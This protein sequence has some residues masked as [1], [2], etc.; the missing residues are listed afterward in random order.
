MDRLSIGPQLLPWLTKGGHS[1]IA[2]YQ[3]AAGLGV[4]GRQKALARELLREW[5]R[6]KALQDS[7][8]KDIDFTF[9]LTHS[10]PQAH[11]VSQSRPSDILDPHHH[12]G[13]TRFGKPGNADFHCT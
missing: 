7:S 4:S 10:I 8:V 5:T 9:R 11:I 3:A 13:W 1:D 2:P 12:D 6:L